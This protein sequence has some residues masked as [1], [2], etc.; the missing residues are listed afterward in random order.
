MG[1]FKDAREAFE[2]ALR[3]APAQPEALLGLGATAIDL[4]DWSLATSTFERL[5]KVAPVQDAYRGLVYS[6]RQ[7]GREADAS[8]TAALA[9][10]L[11]PGD[12]FFSP[13]GP[14]SP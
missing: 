8:D 7:A 13:E 6:Y 5:I 12:D 4:Q 2:E 14:P 10:S 1:R 9:R 3:R 11:F